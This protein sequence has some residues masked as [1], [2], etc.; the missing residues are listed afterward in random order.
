[1]WE[2]GV[3]GKI[4]IYPSLH[5]KWNQQH[6]FDTTNTIVVEQYERSR[7]NSYRWEVK[8]AD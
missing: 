5:T 6:K 2:E 8:I 4:H 7:S 3:I 1:M